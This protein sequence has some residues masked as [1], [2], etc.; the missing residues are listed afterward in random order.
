MISIVFIVAILMAAA[1]LAFTSG[2]SKRI[3]QQNKEY[4]ADATKQM[5]YSID[6]EMQAGDRKYY[7]EGVLQEKT[8]MEQT[9]L[10]FY[11]PVYSVDSKVIGAVIGVYQAAN[12]ITKLLTADYFG[13]RALATTPTQKHTWTPLKKEAAPSPARAARERAACSQSF[14]PSGF[15][16]VRNTLN[17]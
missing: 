2:N 12:K 13:E 11:S 16:K 5:A 10:M 7:T 14:F 3:T 8:G 15:R 9:L 17:P 1:V 6:D 4:L